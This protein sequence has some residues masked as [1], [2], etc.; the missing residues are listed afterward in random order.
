MNKIV[1]IR[2]KYKWIMEARR[3]FLLAPMDEISAVTQV[4]IFCPMM[5]G[6]AV[7]KFTAPVAQSACR[8]PT[9]AEEL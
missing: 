1:P 6:T 3:A 9:E 5:M 8:M 4:P 2:L 7:A